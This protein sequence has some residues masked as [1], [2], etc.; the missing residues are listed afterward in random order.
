ME[1]S[2]ENIIA[3]FLDRHYPINIYNKE[4]DMSFDENPDNLIKQVF[5]DN[6]N[7][8]FYD[9]AIKKL[10]FEFAM[11]HKTWI[12]T[13]ELTSFGI[14]RTSYKKKPLGHKN[15][16]AHHTFKHTPESLNAYTTKVLA[17]HDYDISP[18]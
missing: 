3:N 15:Y 16:V 10:G 9:W 17:S 11:I 7:I 1:Q 4:I 13:T 12:V 6:P 2:I 14:L 8:T 18:V 5:T